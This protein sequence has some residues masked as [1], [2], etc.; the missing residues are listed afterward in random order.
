MRNALR[1]RRRVSNAKSLVTETLEDRRLLT[2]AGDANLDFYFD[3]SD[4]VQIF[5]AGK[6]NDP[7]PATWAEGDFNGDEIFDTGDFVVAFTEGL[8]KTGPYDE[9]A[10]EPQ[11]TRYPLPLNSNAD[12][13]LNYDPDTGSLLM[14]STT[15]ITTFHLHSESGLFED[16]QRPSLFTGLFD[17][18]DAHNAFKLNPA[19]WTT[20]SFTSV[21]PPNLTL[22]QLT[23]DLTIDGSYIQGGQIDVGLACDGCM[24]A[25]PVSPVASGAG[26]IFNDTVALTNASP[27]FRFDMQQSAQDQL[28]LFASF[29]E[30]ATVQLTLNSVPDNIPLLVETLTSDTVLMLPSQAFDQELLAISLELVSG[31]AANVQLDMISNAVFEQESLGQGINSDLANPQSLADSFAAAPFDMQLSSVLGQLDAADAL[32]RFI[33]DDSFESGSLDASWTIRSDDGGRITVTDAFGAG[34]GSYSLVMD[35]VVPAA[36][37]DDQPVLIVFYDPV[38]GTIRSQNLGEL[39]LTTLELISNSGIFTGN[40]V[41]EE[42]FDNVFDVDAD[43]KL[44]ELDPAGLNDWNLMGVAATGLTLEFLEQ[45]LQIDGSLLGGGKPR[46]ELHLD[47]GNQVTNEAILSVDTTGADAVQL[48]F[49]YAEWNDDESAIPAVYTGSVFGDGVSISVDG[50]RWYRIFTP[51][52]QPAGEWHS[53]QIN[54]TEAAAAHNLSL[55]GTLQVKFQQAG[56]RPIPNGGRAYDGIRISTLVDVD[57]YAMTPNAGEYVSFVSAAHSSGSSSLRLFSESGEL[58]ASG[59]AHSQADAVINNFL[60]DGSPLRIAV[61]GTAEDYTLL[62]IRNGQFEPDV[63]ARGVKPNSPTGNT[64]GARI[65]GESQDTYGYVTSGNA[66]DV[67]LADSLG[68]VR[69]AET[70]SAGF[71]GVR[72]ELQ[73]VVVNHTNGQYFLQASPELPAEVRFVA[74]PDQGGVTANRQSVK[75]DSL[76]EFDANTITAN[77]LS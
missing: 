67:R 31:E 7:E 46:F 18:F 56:E 43:T 57:W 66:T 4:F 55:D 30:D 2:G 76:F 20:L 58:L 21:L 36:A 10:T 49:Q 41:P 63:N 15:A 45:D 77:D 52:D 71:D 6:F 75:L 73:T 61:S 34:D 29:S 26:Q 1:N 23:S 37:D 14:E 42:V 48:E 33:S 5:Q 19:G 28:S 68:Q 50:N 11:H 53:E 32:P 16:R 22:L 74:V 69:A 62:T 12:I 47:P 13:T 40:P 8:Y 60:A 38:D 72:N 70:E 51:T 17:T 59:D 44:F 9:A 3:E 24:S 54:L 39:P 65:A 35:G 64:V 27:S 25:V